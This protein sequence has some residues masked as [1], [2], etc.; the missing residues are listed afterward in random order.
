MAELSIAGLVLGSL[1]FIVTVRH[2]VERLLQD[3][4]TLKTQTEIMVPLSFR[5]NLLY[6]KLTI[7]QTFWHI[8]TGTP[9][10][11]FGSYWGTHG[12]KEI[13]LL[14]S[15]V[16]KQLEKVKIEFESKYGSDLQIAQQDLVSSQSIIRKDDEAQLFTVPNESFIG[17][18]SY[19]RKLNTALF[20]GSIFNKHLETLEKS[21]E[22]LQELSEKRFMKTNGDYKEAEW[23]DQVE[24]TAAK[25]HLTNLAHRSSN[26]SQAFRDLTESLNDHNIDFFLCHGTSPDQ[27]YDKV[28]EFSRES[29]MP[30][31]LYVSSRDA[32]SKPSNVNIQCIEEKITLSS[33]IIWE[34]SFQH[35]LQKLY[36]VKQTSDN[37][38]AYV[39]GTQV[40]FIANRQHLPQQNP[41]NLRTFMISNKSDFARDLHGEFSRAERTRLAYELAECALLFLRT[42]WFS[43]LCS[44]C[45]YRL[46]S[47]DLKSLFTTRITRLDHTDHIDPGTGKPC[48]QTIWCEQELS[49]MHIRRLG[50]LLTEI[51]IG[52]PI[53][54]VAY[55]NLDDDIEIDFDVNLDGN[56]EI[57]AAGFRDILRR[58]RR[59][60][61]EDFMEAV[62]YCLR[63]GTAPK[64]VV[65]TDLESFYDHVVEP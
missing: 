6:I 42:E 53:F 29:R 36:R 47:I 61:S 15:H 33:S 16:H 31:N 34:D 64:D 4:D 13:K 2:T 21:M 1:S 38:C 18:K 27:R 35:V 49:S 19:L 57:Q 58:V 32:S 54:E 63:Q 55:N 10:D 9:S 17:M 60:S 7:W 45:I 5:L 22:L 41:E 26:V 25:S 12:S 28:F 23:R 65:L 39:R 8:H 48:P 24:Y 37:V 43:E 50:V 20:T 30:Y 46:E 14:L 11:L 51:A 59:E 44:C 3:V 40:G 56:G 52:R 62:G